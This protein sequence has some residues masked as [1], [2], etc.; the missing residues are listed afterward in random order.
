MIF[1]LCRPE[2]KSGS[3]RG[4]DSLEFKIAYIIKALEISE[5]V[6]EL[7]TKKD[8]RYKLLELADVSLLFHDNDDIMDMS[9]TREGIFR[10]FVE[11][12]IKKALNEN[13]EIDRSLKTY[14]SILELFPFTSLQNANIAISM[15]ISGLLNRFLFLD[16]KS[17]E[18][19]QEIIKRRE[20]L[21]LKSRVLLFF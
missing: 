1:E 10:M 14:D 20:K 16:P 7:E 11:R 5:W 13:V 12:I 3:L 15:K 9:N 17:L 18:E 19:A 6:R 2:I 4:N 8:E 21:G